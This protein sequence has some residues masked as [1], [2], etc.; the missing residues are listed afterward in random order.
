[1]QRGVSNGLVHFKPGPRPNLYL[2]IKMAGG[3][4]DLL[5]RFYMLALLPHR[6]VLN[7]VA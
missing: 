2:G 1:M 6:G 5:H 7:P 4:S 3:D